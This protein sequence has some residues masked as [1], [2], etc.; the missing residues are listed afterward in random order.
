MSHTLLLIPTDVERRWAG[1]LVDKLLR[2][3]Q[4]ELCGFGPI[5]AGIRTT[6]HIAQHRP[7]RVL[8]VGIAGA[9]NAELPMGKAYEFDQVA[10]YG[11]GAGCG[12]NFQTA[13]ELGWHQWSSESPDS[14][15]PSV[16]DTIPLSPVDKMASEN[17]RLLLTVC[18]AS[19]NA[20][21]VAR[22]RVKFPQ[23]LA[24][25]MEGFSVAAAC[26]LARVPLR[27]VRGIS[28]VAG[29][30]EHKHWQSAAAMQAALH[31]ALA[32]LDE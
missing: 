12:S 25:D 1:A 29:D 9:I 15:I 11:I 14:G 28:N 7:E 2:R 27:I 10:C 30:R 18:A 31:M 32:M 20:A 22:H 24:E 16:D 21:D 17:S 5:V 19:A 8:L 3:A 23:A 26:R 13:S 4:V 6:Q